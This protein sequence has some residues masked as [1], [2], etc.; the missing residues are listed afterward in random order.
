METT[1]LLVSGAIECLIV[2]FVAGRKSR[3]RIEALEAE[4]RKLNA[5]IEELNENL[6]IQLGKRYRA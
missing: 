3:K 1:L 5:D 6:F 4:V 2:M